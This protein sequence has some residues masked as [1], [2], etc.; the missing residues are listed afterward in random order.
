[1]ASGT[2]V[3]ADDLVNLAKALKRASPEA[4]KMF[5]SE[6]RKAQAPLR[7][8][9]A[10]AVLAV[11]VPVREK[12][13]RRSNASYSARQR[14]SIAVA[15]TKT[16]QTQEADSAAVQRI[17]GKELGRAG[18]RQAVARGIKTVFKDSGRREW[19][20]GL[21]T[22]TDRRT[23]P[24]GQRSLA[25]RM[26]SRTGWRHPVFGNKDVY[27]TQKPVVPGWFVNTAAVENER[28]RGEMED[29]LAKWTQYLATSITTRFR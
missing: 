24:P 23:M 6:L 22:R 16:F 26:N 29:V 4:R 27:V 25:R 5:G 19:Q 15:R 9:L 10:E 18:L 28:L 12:Q 20:L 2:H 1:M 3:D 11:E 21:R 7:R 8:K 14:A 13:G 17:L